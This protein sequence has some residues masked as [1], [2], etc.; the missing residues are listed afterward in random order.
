MRRFLT[1]KDNSTFKRKLA[2]RREMLKH[3]EETPVI[4]ET[5]GGLG[6]LYM[7]CY[8]HIEN[9]VVF[10]RKPDKSAVLGQQ[11]PTWAVYEG[12]A[13]AAISQGAGS[14][15]TVN[16]LDIDPYGEPW[17]TIDAFLTS[18]RQRAASLFVV[19]NDGVRQGLAISG[20][21]SVESMADA[22]VEFGNSLHRNYLDVCRWMMERKAGQA[23]YGLTRWAGYYCGHGKNMTHYLAKL[24]LR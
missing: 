23:G 20:G 11:R 21:W 9:G 5:H 13:V 8:R 24:E 18:D 19:V 6:K 7:A 3:L 10:E 22:V 17:P 12:D 4:M 2:L 16:V 1:Q 15:L 14:H